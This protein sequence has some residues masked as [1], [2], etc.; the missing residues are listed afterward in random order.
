MSFPYRIS[1]KLFARF[2]IALFLTGAFA[3]RAGN[4][5]LRICAEP[6]NLPMS[7][8]ASRSGFEIEVAEILA[9]DLHRK[10]EI[11]W[12]PQ[13]DR[14]YFRQT[15]G[16]GNCDAIMG[17][18][19]GFARL[20]TTTPWYRTGFVF[21][22]RARDAIKIRSFADP[23]L[24]KLTIGVPATGLGETPPAIALS[25]RDLGSQ[26]RPFSIYD[27]R[28]MIQAV[29]KKQIDAAIVWG[30]F[31]GWFTD[32]GNKNSADEL[33]VQPTPDSDGPLQFTMGISI[34]VR[35]GNLELKKALESAISRHRE[36]I[37]GILQKW[38]VPMREL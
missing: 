31:G 17:V 1:R 7:Q 14:S 4:P 29:A 33:T 8:Q 18:P 38:R 22:T 12:A 11:N 6:N 16:Q 37:A 28:A 26:L 34:G 10:L 27:P 15:V 36:D 24:H 9:M 23:I 19:S 13:R 5:P 21:V 20:T 32:V 25:Q 30:P 3:V 35:K 2:A